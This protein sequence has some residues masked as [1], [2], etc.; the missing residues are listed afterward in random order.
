M[1]LGYHWD[2]SDW[3]RPSQNP[4]PNITEVPGSEVPDSS[5]FHS[6]ESNESNTHQLPSGELCDCMLGGSTIA[7][8]R[9]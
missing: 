5:S 8:T 7:F 2:C 6:N 4:L 1:L 9:S 3:V